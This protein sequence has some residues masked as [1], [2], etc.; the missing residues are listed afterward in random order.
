MNIQRIVMLLMLTLLFGCSGTPAGLSPVTDFDLNR[1]QGL[2]YEIAR[3]DH[4]FERGLSEVT[5]TYSLNQDGSVKVINRGYDAGKKEWKEAQGKAKF[6]STPT[7]GHLKVSFF[8]PFYGGYNVLV[9]DKAYQ[10]ALVSGPDRSYLWVLSRTPQLP[11]ATYQTLVEQAK[12]MGF[13]TEQ[14]LQ[15]THTAKQP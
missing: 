2:W 12:Q 5:A 6:V 4:S 13:A 1:Y 14:L 3:L 9:L 11:T 7:T 10:Y 8:G 15:V